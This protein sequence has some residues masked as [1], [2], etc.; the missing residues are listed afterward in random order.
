MRERLIDE[1]HQ[2]LT[3]DESITSEF[4]AT[5]KNKMRARRLLYGGREVG[6]ALRP[7]FLTRAQYD[8][9]SRSSEI[10]AQACAKIGAALLSEPARMEAV[11]LTERETK[12]ALV[13]PKYSSIAVTTRLDAFITDD[14]IKFV[15][16]NAENPS[17]L[18]D[19]EILNELLGDVGAMQ[20]LAA[21]YDLRQFSPV[22]FLLE[23]LLRT[24]REWG[25]AGVP[26]IAIL[27]WEG[28]PTAN[29]FVLLKDFFVAHGVP[30]VIC[31]PGQLQY[32]KRKL[33][34]DAFQIDLV[35]KRVIIHELLARC[36][37]SHPLIRAYLGGDVCLVNSF[38]CKMLHKKAVFELLTDE[39]NENWFTSTENDIIKR[40][41]PWTRRV[42]ER[43]TRYRGAVVDL[44][45]H[46]RR[47]RQLFVLK[48]NDD[49]GG[50][51]LSIGDRTTAAEWDTALAEAIAGDYVVQEKIKLR[52]EVFP[53]FAESGWAFQPMY[54]DTNPFL[55]G[56]R[57]QGAMVRLSDSPV[58][59]VTSGGGETGFFVLEAE[60][61]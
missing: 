58:V 5:L 4:L 43:Q 10:L 36:E 18:S 53:V 50:H 47:N 38:R 49:Y 35:Y 20:A 56:G 2:A 33:R 21:R 55:F 16:Y 57:A 61:P 34:A 51:G 59:N 13:N 30:T 12:L 24:F 40:T 52:T 45:E 39:G 3:A 60:I 22:E 46:V 26:N 15:E 7:H 27:D 1:Y 37:D 11:G 28:L 8:L 42:S 29:E 31:T 9:L 6:V 25:G 54:V 48:P 41:V 44:V 32:E 14:E 19:Q 23:V 17:S